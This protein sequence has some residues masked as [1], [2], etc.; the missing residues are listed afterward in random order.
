[1]PNGDL[2]ENRDLHVIYHAL[3]TYYTSFTCLDACLQ[4]NAFV[5]KQK[6]EAMGRI[7]FYINKC[8]ADL[9]LIDNPLKSEEKSKEYFT[10][11]GL[12]IYKELKNDLNLKVTLPSHCCLK[13]FS[14]ASK[15]PPA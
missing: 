13:A 5:G 15:A 1:M 4:N 12:A 10:E 6:H 2:I 11:R 3:Y 9:M 14:F 7:A 8:Y